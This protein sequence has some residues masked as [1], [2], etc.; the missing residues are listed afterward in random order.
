LVLLSPLKLLKRIVLLSAPVFSHSP[1]SVCMCSCP[2]LNWGV[3]CL[4][5]CILGFFCFVLFYFLLICFFQD[6]P[7]CTGTCSVDQTGLEQRS[8]CLCLPC[9]GIKG[10]CHYHPASLLR[11]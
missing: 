2:T 11:F 3:S 10:I 9:A 4:F 8:A 1:C 7:G 6:S 5:C